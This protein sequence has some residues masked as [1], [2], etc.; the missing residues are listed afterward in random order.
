[1]ISFAS[2]GR[3]PWHA[4][5]FL[6]AAVACAVAAY[7]QTAR[8]DEPLPETGAACESLASFDQ[9]MRS[10][11]RDNRIPGGALAVAKDGRLVYARGFG[12]AH[13]EGKEPVQPDS[14]FRL[15]SVSKPITGVAILQ[16]VE[17]G[18]LRLEDRALE[19]LADWPEAAESDIDPRWRDVTL[20]ELLQHRG[21]WDRGVSYD[22][23]FRSVEIARSLGIE[24]PAASRDVVRYMLSQ[25]LDFDPGARYAYSNFG[26]CLLGRVIEQVTG[27]DY[28]THVR[29]RLLAP[30]GIH[31]VRVGKTLPAGRID[32]EVHYYEPHPQTGPSVVGR[33]LGAPVPGPYG[34]WY[35]EAMD[36]H[37]GWIASAIDLVRFGSRVQVAAPAGVLSPSSL[38]ALAA[39]PA[40]SAGT[41]TDGTP[42]ETYYGLGWSV[43][44]VGRARRNLWHNGLFAGSSTILVLRHDGLCWAVLFNTSG[45]ADGQPPANKIDGLVHE[46]ANAVERWPAEDQFPAWLKL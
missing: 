3:V 30:L 6:T 9:L 10:F 20:L 8:G 38:S 37:G 13:V 25:P 44:P 35:L 14:L 16:L 17:E 29:T 34:T 24:P 32:R 18:R 12:Y 27:T 11:L 22:P 33:P 19:I 43:R 1:M 15:A 39:R 36:A 46:A 2:S 42:R 26:Y 28:E 45:T 31:D 5:V 23:M 41:N 4:T 21:G 7:S 40:G